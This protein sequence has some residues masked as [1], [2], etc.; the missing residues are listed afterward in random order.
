[1]AFLNTERDRGIVDVRRA[2]AKKFSDN[3]CKVDGSPT[4]K[5]KGSGATGERADVES[6]LT[7]M[8]NAVPDLEIML[9]SV[10][11]RSILCAYARPDGNALT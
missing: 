9:L 3:L 8:A 1:L 4:P 10:R 2:L 11:K 7:E 6:K 5:G